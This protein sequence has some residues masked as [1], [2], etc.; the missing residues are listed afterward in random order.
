MLIGLLVF[1]LEGIEIAGHTGCGENRLRFGDDVLFAVTAG[2]MRQNELPDAGA[3][4]Q[5]GCA[6]GCQMPKLTRHVGF[7]FQ[8]GSFDD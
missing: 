2:Y 7:F 4:G 3:Q 6:A 8:V 5:F 1:H